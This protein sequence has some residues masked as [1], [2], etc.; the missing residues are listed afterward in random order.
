M[1]ERDTMECS[2]GQ[3]LDRLRSW[4]GNRCLLRACVGDSEF[5]LSVRYKRATVD[6]FTFGIGTD[7]EVTIDLRDATEFTCGDTTRF[8]AELRRGLKFSDAVWA[9]NGDLEVTIL[10]T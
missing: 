5:R 2:R 3:F 4:P 1:I 8:P 6:S 7:D 9:K 10:L